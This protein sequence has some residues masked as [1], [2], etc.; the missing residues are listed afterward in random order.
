MK[1]LLGINYELQ[2]FLFDVRL[3]VAYF[4]T[5]PSQLF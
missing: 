3:P 2:F 5:A 1:K 4:A